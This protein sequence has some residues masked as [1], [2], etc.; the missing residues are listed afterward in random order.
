MILRLA[1]TDTNA[2][3]TE[4]FGS[5]VGVPLQQWLGHGFMD[6]IVAGDPDMSAIPYRM[7]Q[8]T[9]N[10]Q[11]PPIATEVPDTDGIELVRLWI[12]SL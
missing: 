9:A 5:T 12:D 8:R 3:A 7:G 1:A 4:L 11:M 10:M 2:A 6:R